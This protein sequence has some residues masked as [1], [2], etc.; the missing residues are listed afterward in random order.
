ML[1]LN[2]GEQDA[3]LLQ[4]KVHV[5]I[6]GLNYT[7]RDCSPVC[8]LHKWITAVRAII[9]R[10]EVDAPHGTGDDWICG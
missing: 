5:E 3:G 4:V 2:T 6:P 7:S 8:L 10:S 1:R 9:P